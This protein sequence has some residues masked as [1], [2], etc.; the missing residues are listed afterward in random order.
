M[1]L[2]P[3]LSGDY[4]VRSLQEFTRAS[5]RKIA[6]LTFE[7]TELEN[8]VSDL[9]ASLKAKD[10]IIK[11]YLRRVALLEF[12]LRRKENGGL[13]PLPTENMIKA[14]LGELGD[15]FRVPV[16]A[17][18]DE[19]APTEQEEDIPVEDEELESEDFG[20]W[21]PVGAIRS[22]LGAARTVTFASLGGSECLVTG[23][24]EGIVKI[25]TDKAD[26]LPNDVDIK[27]VSLS[28]NSVTPHVSLRNTGFPITTTSS[29]PNFLVT[30]DAGGNVS[31]WRAR[32]SVSKLDLFPSTSDQKRAIRLE[33]TFDRLHQGRVNSIAFE[34]D[35]FLVS[36]GNDSTL[37]IQDLNGGG[38]KLSIPTTAIANSVVHV[39]E[40]APHALTGL[41]DGSL[42]HYDLG[43]GTLV[44]ENPYGSSIS[45]LAVA[46]GSLVCMSQADGILTVIDP[47]S[48]SAVSTK[49]GVVPTCLA[50]NTPRLA[51]GGLD[52][53]VSLFDMRNLSGPVISVWSDAHAT[54]RCEGVLSVAFSETGGLLS[55][56]GADGKVRV[57][58][59]L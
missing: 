54:K 57:F 15:D 19:E 26:S 21:R 56:A 1:S 49:L 33:T 46:D 58:K 50:A 10:R 34:P 59:K 5:E 28:Q 8:R 11:E 30:G 43:T 47:R 32:E 45:A 40:Q 18:I 17:E 38:T 41:A 2:S 24:D 9:E 51:V 16:V 4:L 7:K 42:R 36:V 27:N 52:G 37:V 53:S 13:A 14:F 35:S 48:L 3:D 12:A 25:W 44:R 6:D 55:S 31:L 20:E 39:N 23:G 29:V 22:S